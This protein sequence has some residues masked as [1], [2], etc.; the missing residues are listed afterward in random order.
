MNKRILTAT[1]IVS[2]IFTTN[3]QNT[4]Y[5]DLNATGA[6]NGTNWLNAYT[7]IDSAVVH[8]NPGDAIFIKT[9]TYKQQTTI[10]KSL[11]IYGGFNG[12][13]TVYTQANPDANPVIMDAD[14]N[15]DDV[16]N[17][18]V[19]NKGDNLSYLLNIQGNGSSIGLTVHGITFKNARRLA[20][21]GSAVFLRADGHNITVDIKKCKFFQN[22]NVSNGTNGS[23]GGGVMNV[24]ALNG[25]IG[26]LNVDKCWFEGNSDQGTSTYGSVISAW[27]G[28]SSSV[29]LQITNSVFTGNNDI[30]NNGANYVIYVSGSSLATPGSTVQTLIRNCTFNANNNSKATFVWNGGPGSCNLV[31]D[32]NIVSGGDSTIVIGN[33]ATISNNYSVELN[34]NY[35]TFNSVVDNV[36]GLTQT[37]NNSFGLVPGFVDA[38]AKDFNLT[39]SS[40]CIDVQNVLLWMPDTLDYAGQPRFSGA[41]VDIGAYEYS[42]TTNINAASNEQFLNAYPN[43]ATSQLTVETTEELHVRITNVFGQ[44]VLE[45]TLEMGSNTL[46]INA[47]TP[48]I[49]FIHSKQGQALKFIKN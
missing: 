24:D 45:S 49:Y 4:I 42:G 22:C 15:G 40:S 2:G 29:Q 48:G 16:L 21:S 27:G 43:P 5:V 26:F 6:A 28:T 11:S 36:G 38:A 12:T 35:L 46:D 14:I 33:A 25:G 9:G 18:Y 39:A 34:N 13:E 17:D 44:L 37:N 19:T 7:H 41:G 23:I 30:G 47:F 8:A 31:F 20:Y 10:T 32:R 3:A 1:L